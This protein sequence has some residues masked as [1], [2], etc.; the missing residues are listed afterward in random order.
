[1]IDV[2]NEMALSGSGLLLLATWRALPLLAIALLVDLT[3]AR[4][5]PAKYHVCCWALVAV[6]LLLPISLP[7]SWSW[8][9]PFDQLS[10]S[11]HEANAN[12]AAPSVDIVYGIANTPASAGAWPD[13][14]PLAQPASVPKASGQNPVISWQQVLVAALCGAWALLAAGFLLRGWLA[15]VVFALR[16]RTC[17]ELTDSRLMT[18][19]LRECE[20]LGVRRP[21]L[22][23]VPELP[24]PAVFGL[25]R[26]TI[27]LPAELD[28]VLSEQELRW[29]L[30]HELAHVRRRD[31]WLLSLAWLMRSLH[32]FNPVAWLV[33]ARL[34]THVEL[35]ADRLALGGSSLTEATGYGRLLLRFAE[36]QAAATATPGLGFLPFSGGSSLRSRIERLTRLAQTPIWVRLLAS[37]A[38]LA[39][40]TVGLT[41]A[42]PPL[43][44]APEAVALPRIELA[45][46]ALGDNSGPVSA[47]SY[48][49]TQVLARMHELQPEGDAEQKLLDVC[50]AQL[51]NRPAQVVDGRLLTE[52]TQ[53]QRQF[54]TTMLEAWSH[55][56]PRQIVVETRVIQADMDCASSIDWQQAPFI[57]LEKRGSQPA[58]AVRATDEQMRQFLQAA[59]ADA[60][61]KVLF[62]P[63]VT[64]FNGQTAVIADLVQR[65][66]VTAVEPQPDGT[67][68]PVVEVLDNGVKIQL[69]PVVGDDETIELSFDVNVSQIGDVAAAALQYRSGEQRTNVKVDVPTVA[70]TRISSRVRLSPSESV[71][72]AVPQAAAEGSADAPTTAMFYAFRP[73]LMSPLADSRAS[74]R[75]DPVR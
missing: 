9:G 41:D 49:V 15:H 46:V 4:R 44:P 60:R 62:A 50:R 6:R 31:A 35:A 67:L 28:G 16:L 58:L 65:P 59:K 48:D 54:L 21:V 1:M 66:F 2:V 23:E 61:G 8:Q 45:E 64:L 57:R 40:A 75:A 17:R 36:R 32:W 53:T 3:L 72:I 14:P 19:V 30:R 55:A 52:A 37:A 18:L 24:A 56:G 20:N 27:C 33:H 42:A 12:H 38:T 68:R 22:K 25:L 7:S 74:G 47:F 11:W 26:M 13:S 69:V 63:K 70:K 39:L 34:R 51:A 73:Q 71:V 29:V 10:A 43:P 5:L